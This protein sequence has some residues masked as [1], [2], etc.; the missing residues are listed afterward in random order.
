MNLGLRILLD[1]MF[2]TDTIRSN[3]IRLIAVI[4]I[5][6]NTNTICRRSEVRYEDKLN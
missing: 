3:L 1:V 2:S 5:T 6:V 4:I